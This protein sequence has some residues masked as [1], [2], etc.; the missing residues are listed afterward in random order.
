MPIM[1]ATSKEPDARLRLSRAGGADPMAQAPIADLYEPVLVGFSLL[2][3]A[4]EASA[5]AIVRS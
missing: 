3:S 1:V 2:A 5:R 4:K